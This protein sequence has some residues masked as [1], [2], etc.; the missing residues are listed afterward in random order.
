MRQLQTFVLLF[1]YT[2]FL[3]NSF[4]Q[5]VTRWHVSEDA[6]TPLGPTAVNAITFSHNGTQIAVATA[7]GIALYNTYTGTKIARLPLLTNTT[8]AITFS[9]DNRT[10][11]SA[12][13]DFT[14]HFWNMHTGENVT[15]LTGHADPVVALAFSPNGKTLASGS[16][17]E[18]RL[19][20]LTLEQASHTVVLHGHRDMVTTLAFSPDSKM[21]AST[22]FYG[23]ILLWDVETGQLRHNL[24][25]HTDSVLALAF[26]PDNQILASGGYWNTDAESTI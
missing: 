1:I 12:S 8:T 5:S 20:N 17:R 9:P 26:S 6:E 4:A 21:L 14:I 23:T 7:D 10:V 3:P 25:A 11:A 15:N 18:I 2:L 22:S 24:S 16:F 19:W 13:E